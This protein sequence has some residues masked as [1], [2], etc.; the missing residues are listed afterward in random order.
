M[1][2]IG[3]REKAL[4]A[5]ALG[6]GQLSGGGH[7]GLEAERALNEIHGGSTVLLTTSCTHALEM[8]ALLL[9]LEPGDEV[10]I[11]DYTFVSTALA[12]VIHGATPVF[13]DVDE[14][15][16][17]LNP[18]LLRDA[19]TERTKAVCFV[20][21]GGSGAGLEEVTQITAER[22]IVLIEDNAHGL[23]GS[24]N[25]KPLGTFG[26][27]STLSFHETKAVTSGEGGALVLNDPQFK[28][29][30]LVFREKGTDRAQFLAGQVDKYTWRDRGSSWVM[31]ELNAALLSAQLQNF[32]ET[33]SLRGDIWHHY[34]DELGPWADERGYRHS[35]ISPNETHAYHN[36]H[37]R[38]RSQQERDRFISY[39]SSHG[40][41][42]VFHYQSLSSS[43]YGSRFSAGGGGAPVSVEA[44]ETLVRLPL[45]PSMSRDQLDWVIS[46][47]KQF[48]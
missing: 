32:W 26:T 16:L 3:P 27:F 43:P 11:P 36:F 37:L 13:V 20:N 23:G 45:F 46:R 30:A 21:Y 42:A 6:S 33:Q 5:E 39:L 9:D 10:I 25:E 38:L 34:F 1:P 44:S 48:D 18:S 15:S 24:L 29:R 41:N 31:S 8:A 47:V 22:G 2:F 19:I 28:D 35:K 40:V 7:F 14:N 17:N 4:V 12:F